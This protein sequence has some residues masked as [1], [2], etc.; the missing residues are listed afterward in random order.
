MDYQVD[1]VLVKR[2]YSLEVDSSESP[3]VVTS[4]L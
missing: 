1:N 4:Q 3:D 2:K